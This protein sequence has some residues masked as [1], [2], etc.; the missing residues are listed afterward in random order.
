MNLY[1]FLR[2]SLHTIGSFKKKWGFEMK[3][4]MVLLLLIISV[5]SLAGCTIYTSQPGKSAYEI[6]VEHGFKGSEE[7]WL[8]S[9]K[10]SDGKSLNIDDIYEEYKAKTGTDLSFEDFIASYA[11]SLALIIS[12]EYFSFSSSMASF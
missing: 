8:E 10:G 11:C 3:K 5:V 9:L 12:G 7:E 1:Y 6:A 4:V 2:I